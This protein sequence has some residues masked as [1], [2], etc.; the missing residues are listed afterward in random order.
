MASDAPA[1]TGVAPNTTDAPHI[2]AD[3]T[4]KEQ[5]VRIPSADLGSYKATDDGL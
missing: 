3:P 5:F 2:Q 4:L 1:A